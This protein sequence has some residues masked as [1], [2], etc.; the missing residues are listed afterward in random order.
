LGVLL[1]LIFIEVR[2]DFSVDNFNVFD[3]FFKLRS[4]FIVQVER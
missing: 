4:G 1:G 3:I 2:T